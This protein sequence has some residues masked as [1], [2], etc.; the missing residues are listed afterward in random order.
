[1]EDQNELRSIR[2]IFSELKDDDMTLLYSGSFSDS[3][4]DMI[5]DLSGSHFESNPA[6][7]KLHRKTGFLIA[8]CFQNIVRH[9]ESDIE[10]GY[11]VS[12]NAHGNLF[13]ASGN[14]IKTEM[15]GALSEKLDH[16]NTLEKDELKE[17]YLKTL[18]NEEI[19]EKGGAGLGLIEMAR[20]TGNKLDY[21]FVDIGNNL[22]YFYFQLK[23]ELPSGDDGKAGREYD[24][25][26]TMELRIQ[27]LEENIFMVYKGD[28]S[29]ESIAP[30]TDMIEQS[31]GQFSEDDVQQKKTVITLIETLQNM[32]IHGKK[33][34]GNQDGMFSLG[35]KNEH[36][37]ISASNYIS[38]E[39][40]P[41]LESK[42]MELSDLDLQQLNQ[43][44]KEV[45]KQ[46]DPDNKKGSSLGLIE[47]FRRCHQ[48]PAFDFQDVDNENVLYSIQLEI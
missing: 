5:I 24:L 9:N 15:T 1:M 26:H 48:R 4:T 29:A 21:S 34:N 46:G 47:V 44:Y 16:L 38:K 22:S 25:S 11:F 43:R 31:V 28:V 14:V 40:R 7:M 33:I 30:M 19:S 42:L 32:S 13:I 6:L 20:K 12:R 45:L 27:M 2:E 18:S 17:I 39:E 35:K 8:E 36:F 37:S 10:N 41:A 3:V 23:M